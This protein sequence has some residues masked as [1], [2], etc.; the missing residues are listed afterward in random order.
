[1]VDSVAT[2]WSCWSRYEVLALALA[3]GAAELSPEPQRA[4]ELECEQVIEELSKL[5]KSFG[6]CFFLP[7]YLAVE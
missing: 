5:V 1:M 6:A 2:E 7:N 4:K 3:R